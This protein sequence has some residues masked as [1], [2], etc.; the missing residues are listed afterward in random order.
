AATV[1][2]TVALGG[3]ALFALRRRAR[4]HVIRDHFDDI[5]HCYDAWLPLRYREHMV[6]KKTEPIIAGL[7]PL[8]PGGRGLDI[9]W[10]RGWYMRELRNAGA[11]VVGVDTSW[12]QLAAA[13][14][15][16][17]APAPLVQGSVLRL[18]FRRGTFAFAYVVNVLH[19]LPTAAHQRQA[20]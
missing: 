3:V 2:L 12:R 9:G 8:V 4:R 19:H 6:I 14:D 15:Y 20:L 18:P 16:L 10:G 1:W 11:C 5:D 7:R 13:R 17:G